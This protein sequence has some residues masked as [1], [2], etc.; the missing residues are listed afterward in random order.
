MAEVVYFL[1]SE[2]TGLVKIGKSRCVDSRIS[3]L[4]NTSPVEL[5][6]RAIL[7]CRT[8]QEVHDQ[9]AHLR[10]HGE[11]FRHATDLEE[12]M[13]EVAATGAHLRVR[14][15]RAERRIVPAVVPKVVDL[16]TDEPL[17]LLTEQ[18]AAE[19]LGVGVNDLVRWRDEGGGP[20]CYRIGRLTR[21]RAAEIKAWA[22]EKVTSRD[23]YRALAPTALQERETLLAWLKYG[24]FGG[25]AWAARLRVIIEQG[26]HNE[27]Q[28]GLA[29]VSRNARIRRAV[30]G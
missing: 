11:W 2:S 29:G 8:E 13:A 6:L 26:E 12:Y 7:P 10:A 5:I 17:R 21:Y 24:R 27:W 14:G 30:R 23:G 28:A 18:E 16:A 19:L 3:G 25:E 9:F 4:R 22:A 1:Q 20:P 15:P